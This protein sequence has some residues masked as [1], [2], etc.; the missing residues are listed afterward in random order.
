MELLKCQFQ[1]IVLL[2][3]IG[4]LNHSLILHKIIEI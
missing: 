4:K 2:L 1:V 3:Q